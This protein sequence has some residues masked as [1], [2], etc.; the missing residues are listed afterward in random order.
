[1]GADGSVNPQVFIPSNLKITT[2]NAS[3][4]GSLAAIGAGDGAFVFDP[5][6]GMM[7]DFTD[8]ATFQL[9]SQPDNTYALNVQIGPTGRVSICS[10]TGRAADGRQVPG[11]DPCAAE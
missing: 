8:V 4:K 2:D 9:L 5:V 10:D 11:Y 6:R 3:S 7:V 1:V